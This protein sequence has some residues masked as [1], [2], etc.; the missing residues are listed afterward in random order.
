MIIDLEA[1]VI[2]IGNLMLDIELIKVAYE[3]I[4]Q[5]EGIAG[6]K[7]KGIHMGRPKLVVPNNYLMY[8]N[9]VANKEITA[10]NAANKMNISRASYYR[11]KKQYETGEI[12]LP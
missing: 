5:A 7:S 3:R 4:K 8:Y 1:Q 10:T 2:E 6:A 12:I 9:M 11:I